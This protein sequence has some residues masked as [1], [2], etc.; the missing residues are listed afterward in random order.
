MLTQSSAEVTAILKAMVE[1]TSYSLSENYGWVYDTAWALALG[2]NNSLRHLNDSGLD[3][4][5]NNPYYLDAILKGMYGVD[6]AGI[7]VSMNY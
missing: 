3:N 2:L 5:T 4:Y 1:Q 6:F 7:S